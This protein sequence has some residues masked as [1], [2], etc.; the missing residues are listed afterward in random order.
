MARHKI[1]LI[2][3]FVLFLALG[4]SLFKDYGASWDEG[5]QREL[6][7]LTFDY[8][9]NG[10]QRILHYVDRAYGPFFEVVLVALEKGFHLNDNI[11]AI[12]L[13]RHLFTFLLFYL[14]VI[15]FL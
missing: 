7:S 14:G 11:R 3:F 13:M 4:V 10:D 12:F 2:L 8:V 15:F 9:V 5:W 1:I 6:G